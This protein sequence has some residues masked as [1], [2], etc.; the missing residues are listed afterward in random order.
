MADR[1]DILSTSLA[2]VGVQKGEGE[3]KFMSY[4]RLADLIKVQGEELEV[5][6]N[7]VL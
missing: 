3:L 5:Q 2:P 6:I 4:K 1:W 7:F